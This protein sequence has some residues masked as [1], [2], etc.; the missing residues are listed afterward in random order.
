V[1]V[2][3]EDF[4]SDKAMKILNRYRKHHLCFNDDIQG[5]GTVCVF[6]QKFALKD[7][8]GSHACSLQE[9]AGVCT[10][11]FL[12]GV[13]FLTG[14]HCKLRL[15]TEGAVAVAG[16][17]CALRQQGKSPADFPSQKIVIAGAGSAG[18]GVANAL[19]DAMMLE[20]VSE[21]D[22]HAQFWVVDANGMVRGF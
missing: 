3:F 12:S 18:L 2:Q 13:H 6:Q 11:T 21:E 17:L 19:V 7:A 4:S 9:R 15:N 1:F 5:T 14:S 20:G 10:L 8:I 22:A 16:V